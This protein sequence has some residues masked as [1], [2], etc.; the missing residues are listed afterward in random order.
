MN[1]P[2]TQICQL[3]FC[4]LVNQVAAFLV[5]N[6]MNSSS[7]QT[8]W[9]CF[10]ELVN[11]VVAFLVTNHTWIHHL[12][13]FVG[14]AF[15]NQLTESWLSLLKTP[16]TP[17][18]PQKN[19]NSPTTQICQLCFCESVDSGGFL[20]KNKTKNTHEF[21][22]YLNLSAAFSVKKNKNT[23]ICH[24]QVCQVYFC[25]RPSFICIHTYTFSKI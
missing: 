7:T 4:E 25:E 1:S 12:S 14:C 21:T 22:N 9:L 15:M 5:K 20:V 8:H 18:H 6:A 13:R 16:P 23:R 24:H 19:M 2:T 10:C 3:C 11:Q 17:H